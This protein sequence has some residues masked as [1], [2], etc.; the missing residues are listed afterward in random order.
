MEDL[1]L[2]R[3]P[4][5]YPTEEPQTE[6]IDMSGISAEPVV[7][8]ETPPTPQIEEPPQ[9][10][11]PKVDV[12][13]ENLNKEFGTQYKDRD[14]I[15]NIFGL[16]KKVTEYET[17]LKESEGLAK[18]IE[19]YKKKITELEESQDPLK[20]FSSPDTYI[21]EQLRI[22]YPKSN[23]VLL[24]EIATTDVNKMGDLDVLIKDKQLFVPDAPKE[25]IIRSVVLKKYGID[26][27]VPPE[28]WDEVSVGEMKL[29]AAAARD[30]I[31]N[32]KGVIEMPVV[33][34]KEQKQALEAEAIAKKEQAI[35]PLKETFSK[36]DKFSH[37]EIPGFEFDVPDEFRNKCPDIFQSMFI[38][39]GLEPNEDGMGI[40]N[41]LRD[42]LF[43]HKYLPKL[44]EIWTKEGETEA[45]KRYDEVSHNT[46]P[47]NTAT[48]TDQEN[49]N[50]LPGMSKYLQDQGRR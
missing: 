45:T 9:A 47:P 29:D 50:T 19:D 4:P 15:K 38:D 24:Q 2:N 41:D 26:P 23:P 12:F 46:Q 1:N 37:K 6:P 17:K 33:L 36:F 21:A 3:V 44:R 8:T 25:G 14:E 7:D 16:P 43:V 48:L 31:N 40:A 18:S 28:E 13:I 30:K 27:T 10:E 32:L 5:T 35:A 22:K 20:Y 42:A 49:V 11:P 34:T 39:A